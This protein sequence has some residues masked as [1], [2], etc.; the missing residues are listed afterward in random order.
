ML[1]AD[2]IQTGYNYKVVRMNRIKELR[3]Q[4]KMTQKELANCLQIS[5]STLSYWEIGKYEPNNEGLRKLSRFFNVPIDYII[6]VD[7]SY[8]PFFSGAPAYVGE[9][10]AEY[11]G[12]ASGKSINPIK[13]IGNWT[14]GYA[15]DKHIVSSEY[16]GEDVFGHKQFNNTYTEIGSLLY[17]MK[18]NGH[19]D[20]SEEIR[21]LAI[22][23]LDKWLKDKQ[24]DII[25]PVPPTKRRDIQ[26]VYIIAEAIAKYYKIPYSE[27]VIT[28]ITAEQAK[29]MNKDEKSLGGSIKLL[30]KPKRKC[31]V[32]LIDDLFS[33]GRTISECAQ[34][35]KNEKLVNNIYVLT[36][37]K[38][39]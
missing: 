39:G 34:V 30:K 28:K 1:S 9:S 32:L 35:L 18:Y 7:A 21:D 3:K 2:I 19:Y 11:K 26:P 13:L 12:R 31:D 14:E 37:T 23:F 33:T 27:D 16:I 4:N 38:T 36:I 25:L 8:E 22:P 6:G 24:I 29:D 15:L 10:I 17:K 20:T 5:D